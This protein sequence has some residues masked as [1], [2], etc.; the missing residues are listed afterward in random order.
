MICEK[1]ERLQPK[2]TGRCI[3]ML[4]SPTPTIG[5]V[6][7]FWIRL[8]RTRIKH[9]VSIRHQM[10]SV[11]G[12]K[13]QTITLLLGREEQIGRAAERKKKI[14]G[15][16]HT[17]DSVFPDYFA[18]CLSMWANLANWIENRSLPSTNHPGLWW[19]GNSDSVPLKILN[20]RPW[21]DWCHLVP[22]FV[23]QSG[24]YTKDTYSFGRTK[25]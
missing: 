12:I 5:D 25:S 24:Y 16:R 1:E 9:V 21:V 18:Q 17:C 14:E 6:V 2:H 8:V 4:W 7:G 10:K 22:F 23:W 15:L 19:Y 13:F 3:M 11:R 20:P